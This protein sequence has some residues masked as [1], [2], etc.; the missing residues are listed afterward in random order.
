[1]AL[2]SKPFSNNVMR[3][4]LVA[5]LTGL[6]SLETQVDLTTAAVDTM[7]LVLDDVK[8]GTDKIIAAAS[9]ETKQA[10]E[11]TLYASDTLR[12]S[13]DA[14]ESTNSVAYVKM[15]EFLI[16]RPGTVRIRFDLRSGAL[17]DEVQG[18][19]YI[20]GD[21]VGI[22]R[23]VNIATYTTFSED[24]IVTPLDLIQIYGKRLDTTNC[25]IRNYRLYADEEIGAFARGT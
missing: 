8:I 3:E 21:V 15:K 5:I 23:A 9:I 1:M 12:V 10:K 22:L 14:E 4:D 18:R 7:K 11:Y 17:L 25:F 24:V 16:L 19:I 2:P 13:S 20:N 6:D